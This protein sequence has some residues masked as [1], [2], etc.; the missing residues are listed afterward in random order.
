MCPRTPHDQ[1]DHPLE[2]WPKDSAL[3]E[4]LRFGDL[5]WCSQFI[6]YL[7]FAGFLWTCDWKNCPRMCGIFAYLNY[8]TP[9]TRKEILDFLINGLKRLEYRGYDSA[10]KSLITS[11]KINISP[12][13]PGSHCQP[14]DKWKSFSG[15]FKR[16][17][18]LFPLNNFSRFLFFQNFIILPCYS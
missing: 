11:R 8:L 4:F 1:R 14:L 10:G 2:N 12:L 13:P 7:Y 17:L 18:V 3:T 9:K 15:V 16:G 6:V 5:F